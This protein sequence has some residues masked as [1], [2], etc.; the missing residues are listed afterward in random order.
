MDSLEAAAALPRLQYKAIRDALRT[1]ASSAYLRLS[2]EPFA[3]AAT[4]RFEVL[5]VAEAPAAR[6]A[7]FVCAREEVAERARRFARSPV[8]RRLGRLKVFRANPPGD[9]SAAFDVIL[10]DGDGRRHAIVLTDGD[11]PATGSAPDPVGDYHWAVSVDGRLRPAATL[12]PA[13]RAA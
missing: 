11:A 8:A 1:A 10:I 2:P 12:R 9:D 13:I 3:R 6:A 7:A 4:R 5:V